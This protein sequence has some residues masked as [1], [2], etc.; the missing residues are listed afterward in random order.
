MTIG[1]VSEGAAGDIS[2]EFLAPMASSNGGD[3]TLPLLA[4]AVEWALVS[5]VVALTGPGL[6][7]SLREEALPQT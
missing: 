1:N 4:A 3:L 2:C 7:R 6:A 5:F